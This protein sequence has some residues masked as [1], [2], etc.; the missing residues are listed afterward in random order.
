MDVPPNWSWRS[1]PVVPAPVVV[2]D[3]DGVLSDAARRQHF[4]EGPVR[5]W[6]GFFD[7]C[8]E[9]PIIEETKV[10]L[11]LLDSDLRIVLLTARPI[12]LL[13]VTREWLGR[14][15]I[16]W[17]LLIMRDGTHGHLTSLD[18]KHASLDELREYGFELRL[19]I[20]DDRRNVA[21]LRAAGVPAL[22]IH[23]GY[24]D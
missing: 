18:F 5:D 1:D 8:G 9:D 17:D 7:A 6:R 3:L 21:M 14:F 22:Y 16:R 12:R 23:S 11:D 15:A 24:Y 10:L 4:L 19:G 2:V 20:E 13:D